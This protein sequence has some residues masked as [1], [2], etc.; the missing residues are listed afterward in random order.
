M[1]SGFALAPF[2]AHGFEGSLR[3]AAIYGGV[4]LAL[5]ATAVVEMEE[6]NVFDPHVGNDR[7]IPMKI[8]LPLSMVSSVFGVVMSVFDRRGLE[9]APQLSLWLAPG[10]GGFASG[11]GWSGTL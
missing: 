9:P 11:F 1:A 3:K 10:A 2:V 4:S 6:R 7:R 8:F 5:S